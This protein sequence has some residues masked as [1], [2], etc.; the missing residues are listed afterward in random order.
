[1]SFKDKDSL[2]L[3][4]CDDCITYAICRTYI[5]EQLGKQSSNHTTIFNDTLFHLN[6]KCSLIRNY[7]VF[8]MKLLRLNEY[9]HFDE[10]AHKILIDIFKL[11]TYIDG[12]N[13]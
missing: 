2:N 8:K 6:V 11:G 1:M 3:C 10:E 9:I 13:S 7:M 12:K 4:P 5:L